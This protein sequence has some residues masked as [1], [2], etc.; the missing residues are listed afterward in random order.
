[1]LIALRS[2]PQGDVRLNF[3][4][5]RSL[6]LAL[7]GVTLALSVSAIAQEKKPEAQPGTAQQKSSEPERENPDA[8]SHEPGNEGDHA[9]VNKPVPPE[10]T[11]VTH[12]EMS[13]NGQ[14][15][16]YT[17]TAGNLIIKDEQEKPYGSIFYVAYTQDGADTRT[18][19]VTFLYN[20][21]PGSATL[22]LHMGSVGPVRVLTDSPRPTVGPPFQ[23]VPNKD[24]LLD[25]SDL[26][27][28]DAPMA[29][30]SR[31]VGKATAKDFAG[32]DQDI[33][34]FD[35]FIMRWVTVNQRWNS[36]KYL[37]GESYGTTRS[38]GLVAALN[39]D[40]LQFN[41]VILVSSILNYNRRAP[42]LDV[43]YINNFPSFAAIAFYHHK[44]KA[45]GDIRAWVQS[46]RQFARGPYA[47]ALAQGDALSAADFDAMAQR[48]SDFTGLSVQYL[49]EA[50]LRV[51]PS[52]FRKELL[53]DQHKILGRYDARF[54]AT[55]EDAAGDRPTFDPSST[56]IT[57]A[58]VAAFHDYLQRDLKYTSQET[59]YPSAPG[60]NQ[61]WDFKHRPANANG[62]NSEQM[63]VA[64][65]GDIGDTIRKNPGL[66]IFSANGFY[67]LATPFFSTEWDL[68]HLNLEPNLRGNIQFG[69]YE[70]GHMMYLNPDALSA[71]KADLARFYAQGK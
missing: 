36:P 47:D 28:I 44:V 54:E 35:R 40:G 61:L 62:P 22:W 33:R 70:G 67:D 13:L 34:A 37:M 23:V 43:D 18:R 25:K 14:A 12:H 42:Q 41:G 56:G 71:L 7:A 11:S 30:F 17:A 65:A 57:G 20:G 69:Y 29:G 10:T 50:N 48:V 52:R 32:V 55:D 19:P 4:F 53:R 60:V 8:R 45:T 16:H 49:H 21:G 58:F 64:V 24:S 66:R 46:A 51:D 39:S 1:V 38:A 3:T 9:A 27:F 15:I 26:V 68:K 5:I 63:V 6:R 31:A 2:I 59:Y